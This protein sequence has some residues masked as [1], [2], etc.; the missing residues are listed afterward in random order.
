MKR[1]QN[2]SLCIKISNKNELETLRSICKKVNLTIA[3]VTEDEEYPLYFFCWDQN[4]KNFL[5]CDVEIP[6]GHSVITIKEIGE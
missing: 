2:N 1:V 4:G 3:E 5:F 6:K